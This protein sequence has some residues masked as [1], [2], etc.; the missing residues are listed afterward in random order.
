MKEELLNKNYQILEHHGVYKQITIWIEE[1][2]E[3][4]K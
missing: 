2:S 4:T 3:L 1:M